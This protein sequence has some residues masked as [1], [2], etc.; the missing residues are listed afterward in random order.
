MIDTL[1]LMLSDVEI[2]PDNGVI[3]Q[4]APRVA[5]SG[6]SLGDCHL[7]TDTTGREAFG[8]KAYLNTPICNLTIAPPAREGSGSLFGG[9]PALAFVQCSLPK[10]Y[11]GANPHGNYHP[12]TAPQAREALERVEAEL[13][14][15]GVRAPLLEAVPSRVDMF[16]NVEAA[17]P[18]AVYAPLFDALGARRLQRREYGG[19]GYLWHNTQQEYCVYDKLAELESTGGSREGLPRN[20]IRFERRLLKGGKVR[21]ELPGLST[22]R[23]M[24]SRFEELGDV[25]RGGVSRDVLCYQPEAVEAWSAVDLERDMEHFRARYPRRWLDKYVEAIGAT[26][27]AER[28]DIS[29]VRGVVERLTGDRK[30]AYRFA[31][32][33]EQY[34]LDLTMQRAAP[35]RTLR[36]LYEELRG[37]VLQGGHGEVAKPVLEAPGALGVV[38]ERVSAAE[39]AW[40][41]ERRGCT[42]QGLEAEPE[43]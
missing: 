9:L 18:F 32:K 28:A 10:V 40:L 4:P 19:S 22:A 35:P 31:R 15:Y 5:G 34:A 2:A 13:A 20:V 39:L 7:W 41:R 30:K 25:F 43:G 33:L 8:S 3:L 6:E 12:V 21:R 17:E 36:E 11:A 23:V 24:L 27:I 16:V 26:R 1:R 38:E 29:T 37:K 14:E 42:G